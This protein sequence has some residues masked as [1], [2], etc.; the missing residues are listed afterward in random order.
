MS[1]GKASKRGPHR[2]RSLQIT[3]AALGVLAGFVVFGR[4]PA[5]DRSD[6]ENEASGRARLVSITPLPE[7]DGEM[8]IWEPVSANSTLM[9]LLAQ[10]RE[11]SRATE[12]ASRQP[13]DFSQRK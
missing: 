8:C 9:S 4:D 2:N 6:G 7:M 1:V 12:P 3:L 11:P 10:E 5:K 13:V